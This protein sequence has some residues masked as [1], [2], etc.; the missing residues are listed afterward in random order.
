MD[1]SALRNPYDYRNPVRDA[2]VFAGRREE[3]D[4]IGYELDQA[5][6]DRP[7]VCVVLHGP[8][9]AGKTSLLNATEWMA[10]ERGFVAARTELIEG[11]GEPEAFF[12]KLYEELVA[13]VVTAAEQDGRSLPFD[14]PAVR[15]A[16][17]GAADA[18]CVSPLQFPEAMALAGPAG[19]V[20]EAALRADL[21]YFVE[22]LGHPIVLLVDEAQLMADDARVLSILRFLVSRVDGLV[23]VLA[24]TAGLID[25]ITDVHSPILRQFKE[26]P[27][28]AFLEVE[29]VR[30]CVMR[31]LRSI[32]V[33][34]LPSGAVVSSLRQ[35]TDGNPYEIQL[36]CHEMFARWQRGAAD[37]MQLTAEV[38]EGIRSRME[39][40]RD[41]L[42]R[43]LI[44]AVR[45]MGRRD[46]I[47]FNALTSALSHATADDAWFA[48]NMAGTPEITRE[49]YD[50]CRE[51]L[52]ADGVLEPG[53]VIRFAA[54]TE[55]FDEI[56]ARLWTVGKVGRVPHT[57]FTSRGDVRLLLVDRLVCLLCDLVGPQHLF[58]TCCNRMAARHV[59]EIFGALE[60]L[61]DA[62]PDATPRIELLHAAVLRAGEPS[63]LD[64]TTVTC[65]YRDHSVQRWLSAADTDDIELT[66][67]PGFATAA[68]RIARFGGEL[69]AERVRIPLRSWP[70]REWFLKATGRL[71]AALAESHLQAGFAGYRAGDSAAARRH[72]HASYTFAPGWKPA[73]NL[74]YIH[75]TAGRTDDAVS[76]SGRALDLAS[77]PR[78]RSLSR[79]NAAMAHLMAGNRGA[80]ADHLAGAAEEL[81]DLA[82]ADYS[83]SFLLLPSPGD[84]PILREETS[85]SLAEAV[86]RA[87]AVL[88]IAAPKE[89]ASGEHGDRHAEV[90]PRRVGTGAPLRD[91]RPASERRPVVLAVATEWV[92]SHGGL[93]TFNRE[94][95]RALASAGARVF[96]VVP[97]TT[98]EEAAAAAEAG[99]VLLPAPRVPGGSE[100]LRLTSRPELPAGTVPDV[101]IGHSRITGP[102]AKK[103]ADDF[104]PAACR[105]HF[106]HMA[107]DEIEWHKPGRGSD[108]ALLAEQRTDV[109][110]DLGKTAH[111]VVAVGPRLYD[112]FLAEFTGP[113]VRPPV[114]LDPG[115][116]SA[117][118]TAS[119][120][121]PGGSPLRVLF[122]GRAEDAGLKGLDLAAAACGRVENWLHDDGLSSVRLL[123][124]GAPEGTAGD[125]RA[126]VTRWAANPRL[127]VV[128]RAY[129]SAR[130]R[131][132]NDLDSTS[133]VI[134]PSRSEGFGLVGAEAIARGVPVL[135][136]AESGLAQLLREVLGRE[137]AARF[138]VDM[139]GD[140]EKDTDRWARAIDRKLR[141]RENAFQQAAELRKILAER[142]SWARAAAVV[143]DEIESR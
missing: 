49:Q 70:A 88:G 64:L 136:S 114:R 125:V 122:S 56:Y 50:R 8:R 84:P 137:G 42:D 96:C 52:V 123:V 12:R 48:Y 74:A 126:K 29:D 92:S 116:D 140:G 40:G 25:R 62:G 69:T 46:L 21:S 22:F 10:A 79:Y 127:T 73:N 113:E 135:V 133:L 85:V 107:P 110:R 91:R 90:A 100:D 38:L 65:T 95:C 37:G 58:P 124:R 55:L 15:R 2:S 51:M 11:D 1:I 71:R 19:R 59:E 131:L 130:D 109:E 33:Y 75:L 106:V 103:L 39:S 36:Y 111:R 115:F 93:S 24:G 119:R 4:A 18:G 16:M 54:R 121:P 45:A 47:A 72:F 104:Y 63:A 128:V 7:S 20:P 86:R 132:D 76:W 138:V 105:L 32:G 66:E 142:V 9:A 98:M 67:H 83:P 23:L 82:L 102:A 44:R 41:V 60:T 139:S 101:V 117:A 28:K 17:S 134:M 108:A 13:A 87:S 30:D 118:P 27:V 120:T 143:L 57:L 80:A 53:E 14:A 112:Q 6:I 31:P 3:A 141:D 77:D 61:P 35:L 43:P 68:E 89:S 26:I 81:K 99:V 78:L 129:A 34:D 94:L 5:A 97:D